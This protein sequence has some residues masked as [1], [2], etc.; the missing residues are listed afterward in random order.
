M[1]NLKA[2]FEK[3]LKNKLSQKCTGSQSEAQL[4]Q[5]CFKYFDMNN[6]GDVDPNEFR[7]AVEKIGIFIPTKEDL[8]SL[9]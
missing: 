7:Q 2:S 8:N 3:E 4:L 6:S 9:F 1:D 5:K